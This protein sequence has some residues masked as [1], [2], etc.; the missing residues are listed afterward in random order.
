MLFVRWPCIVAPTSFSTQTLCPGGTTLSMMRW[1]RIFFFSFF[2]CVSYLGHLFFF[3][4]LYSLF[5]QPTFPNLL[6]CFRLRILWTIYSPPRLGSASYWLSLMSLSRSRP[7]PSSVSCEL[8]Q[9][10]GLCLQTTNP[11]STTGESVFDY[12]LSLL[13]IFITA[14]LILPDFFV[15]S[16]ECSVLFDHAQILWEFL[17][18]R[19]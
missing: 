19:C 11:L 10:Q 5:S 8:S 18:Q 16:E 17:R 13:F 3:Y 9:S 4:T 15:S 7:P 1:G 12:G 2:L 6:L 14:I